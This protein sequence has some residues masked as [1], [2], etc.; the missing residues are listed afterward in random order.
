MGTMTMR[1]G[2]CCLLF[3][4]VGAAGCGSTKNIREHYAE[5]LAE[6]RIGMTVAEFREILPNAYLGGQTGE[7]T[8]YIVKAY[9]RHAARFVSEDTNGWGRAAEHLYFY[10][11]NDKL[12][13]WGKPGDWK[14]PS[15][16]VDVKV[17]Q[18]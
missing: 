18:E 6:L 9:T 4:C 7:T 17:K 13:R 16:D 2:L 11:V 15:L 5:Q 10:F 3:F 14:T 1:A 12:V 8:A